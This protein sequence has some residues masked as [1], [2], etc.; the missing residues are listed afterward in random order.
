MKKNYL[1]LAF[2]FF[3]CAL[4]IFT[5]SVAAKV[6][7][8]IDS[9]TFQQIPIAICDFDN[10][11]TSATKSANFG[12][13][14]SDD[15]KKDLSLTGMFNILNKKSF[16]EN[17]PPGNAATTENIRFSD[18]A[19][20]GADYLLQGSITQNNK[21]IIVESRLLMLPEENFFSTKNTFL[22]STN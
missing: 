20:I 3:F 13:T 2:I 10:Q 22:K 12:I 14:V 19:T 11:I 21:E 15:V 7:V 16:L 1:I 8:D 5:N 6:Y 18:W 4:S 17:N 9:P